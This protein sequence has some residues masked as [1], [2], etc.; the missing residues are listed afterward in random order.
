MGMFD[1]D[2]ENFLTG[3]LVG[4]LSIIVFLFII[5]IVADSGFTEKQQ[6]QLEKIVREQVL[7]K[8]QEGK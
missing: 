4:V 7:S 3:M 1:F 5:T 6:L 2:L 8:Q